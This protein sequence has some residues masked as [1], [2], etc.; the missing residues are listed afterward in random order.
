MKESDI[1]K[2]LA[3][4]ERAVKKNCVLKYSHE[5]AY[6]MILYNGFD[7]IYCNKFLWFY[8]VYY[9]DTKILMSRSSAKTAWGLLKDAYER[10]NNL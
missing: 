8:S 3:D 1:E 10:K 7:I 4:I 2:L 5:H 6:Y 9:N